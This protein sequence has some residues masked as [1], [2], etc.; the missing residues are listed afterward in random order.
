MEP[1][2]E[3][4]VAAELYGPFTYDDIDL[5]DR[6]GELA[7]AVRRLVPSCVALS[8]SLAE[9][10][11]T[12]VVATERTAEGFDDGAWLRAEHQRE[13]DPRGAAPA[14]ATTLSLP[15]L[16]DSPVTSGFNLYAATSGAFDGRHEELGELLG[17]W[18]GGAVRDADLSFTAR[19]A[20]RRAPQVLRDAIRLSMAVGLVMAQRGLDETEARGRLGAAAAT[21]RAPLERVVDVV[22]EVLSA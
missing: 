16:D 11:V 15:V 8:Y 12:F 19:D 9:D 4:R 18:P 17:V 21:A 1:L 22:V 10:G 3:S 6:L 7:E 13:L 20:A 2:L 14:V 5:L